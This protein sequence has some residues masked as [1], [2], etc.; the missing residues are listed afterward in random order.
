V[1]V[2]STI[3]TSCML[4]CI[5]A[6]D[7]ACTEVRG[8]AARSAWSVALLA[9]LALLAP[10]ACADLDV[11]VLVDTPSKPE[12]IRGYQWELF[13]HP[14]ESKMAGLRYNESGSCLDSGR[15]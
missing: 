3:A 14:L 7:G 12:E 10:P 15:A 11:R 5:S 2:T 1:A 13:I 9:L 8:A 6:V 4:W